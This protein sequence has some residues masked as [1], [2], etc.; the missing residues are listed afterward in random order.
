[1]K[2]S[3]LSN[4]SC[5]FEREPQY[6]CGVICGSDLHQEWLLPWWWERYSTDNDLPVTFVDLG[7]SEQ[8][9]CFCRQRGELIR[10]PYDDS[11]VKKENEID[12][13]SAHCWQNIYGKTLWTS[14]SSWFRKPFALLCSH[15][16]KAVWLDLDCEVLGAIT[17][18]FSYCDLEHPLALLVEPNSDIQAACNYN[19]G[20]I[21]F[22]HGAKIIER[23]AEEAICSNG[24]YWSD[25]ALLSALVH[26]MNISVAELPACYN[27]RLSQ[28][29]HL[30]PLIHH[31]VGSAGKAYIKHYGGLKNF[32][33]HHPV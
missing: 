14:R 4:L 25:D 22:M 19:G 26:K 23:W 10:L 6:S 16:E 8:A 27:W 24:L 3:S 11:F 5:K 17:P 2:R 7:M 32:L 30:H 29:L 1:M 20:V 21:V 31:W 12:P 9:R 13:D 33:M 15:Y 18:L 28:G